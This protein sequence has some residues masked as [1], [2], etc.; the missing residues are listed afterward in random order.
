M[1]D[2]DGE[3]F[4][5]ELEIA[6]RAVTAAGEC[7]LS[8]FRKDPKSWTKSGGTPVTEADLAADAVLR[9]ELAA[10]GKSDYGWISEESPRRHQATTGRCW[11]VDPIDGTRAFLRGEE[12]WAVCA[13]LVE[14]GRP[15]VACI[16]QPARARLYEAAIGGGAQLNGEPL[17]ASPRRRLQGCRMIGYRDAFKS[18]RWGK[19]WP[20]MQVRPV[21]SMALRLAMVAS[22]EADATLTINAK[23]DWDLAAADLLVQEA[24]GKITDFAGRPFS[25]G[26]AETRKPDV[27]ASGPALSDALLTRTRRWRAQGSKT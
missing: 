8:F 20:P 13:A 1:P 21:N 15:L 4:I 26:G 10:A 14:N 6:R 25:Y 22:A 23:S 18:G 2:A 11:I 17:K 27:T 9:R 3:A 7:A 12:D 5:E 19:P 24:G 16:F